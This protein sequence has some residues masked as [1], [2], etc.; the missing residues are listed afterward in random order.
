MT[1]ID[2]DNQPQESHESLLGGLEQFAGELDRHAYPGQAWPAARFSHRGRWVWKAAGAIAGLAA[3]LGVAFHY[4][5]AS[6]P[7]MA[8]PPGHPNQ[9][10]QKPSIGP[11]TAPLRV[12]AWDESALPRII[13][14]EDMDS[15]SI[16]DL[17]NDMPLVSF[18][19]K[20]SPSLDDLTPILVDTAV[21][22]GS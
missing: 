19:S 13:I 11:S 7:G 6:P 12:A 21:D 5:Q 15:Y 10:V 16:I 22:P 18:A 1:P 14:V 17:N 9:I 8:P 2:P 4:W 20:D 3:M